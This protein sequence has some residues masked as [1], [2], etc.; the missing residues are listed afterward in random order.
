M[1]DIY[2]YVKGN[3]ILSDDPLEQGLRKQALPVVC[4]TLCEGRCRAHAGG[5]RHRDRPAGPWLAGPLSRGPGNEGGDVRWQS[6]ARAGAQ[7]PQRGAPK[8]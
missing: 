5:A 6:G 3:A 2:I 7:K 4:C 8:N 1:Y